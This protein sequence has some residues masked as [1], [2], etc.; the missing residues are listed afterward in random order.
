MARSKPLFTHST[1][2][3]NGHCRAHMSY[4]FIHK[5]GNGGEGAAK[6]Q[7]GE[8]EGKKRKEPLWKDG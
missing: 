1:S 7:R 8:E 5:E 3:M 2:S 4:T 6:F